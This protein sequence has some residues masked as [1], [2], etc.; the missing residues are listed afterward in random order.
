MEAGIDPL[1]IAIYAAIARRCRD[2]KDFGLSRYP[3]EQGP[4]VGAFTGDS[5]NTESGA[6]GRVSKNTQVYALCMNTRPIISTQLV[7]G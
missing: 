4:S 5:L 3:Y 7:T 1:C 2:N 6:S